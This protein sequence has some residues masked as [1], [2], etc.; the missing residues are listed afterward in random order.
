[1]KSEIVLAPG[2]KIQTRYIIE[3]ELGAGGMGKVFRALD[4]LTNTTVAI[5]ILSENGEEHRE[6]FRRE[7]SFFK[8]AQHPNLLKVYEFFEWNSLL[9]MVIEFI[10]G[11]SMADL[12]K[13]PKILSLPEQLSIANKAARAVEILNTGGILHRDIKPDNIMINLKNGVVKLLDLGIGRDLEGNLNTLTIG[14]LGTLPYLSPEQAEE[15]YSEQSDIFSLGVTLY[16]FFLWDQQSPFYAANDFSVLYKISRYDPPDLYT[17]I[18]D[19]CTKNAQR[20]S[21]VEDNAYQ[22]LSGLLLQAMQKKPEKRWRNSGEMAAK[23]AELQKTFLE[24]E[25]Y[26]STVVHPDVLTLTGEIDAGLLKSLHQIQQE[27]KNK[28]TKKRKK[29]RKKTGHRSQPRNQNTLNSKL[30]LA[31]GLVGIA[32]LILFMNITGEN[33]A[34][35]AGQQQKPE[36]EIAQ[37]KELQLQKA[38]EY[39]DKANV[40]LGRKDYPQAFEYTR[41]SAELGNVYAMVLLGQLYRRGVGVKENDYKAFEWFQKSAEQGHANGMANMGILYLKG[42]G[43]KPNQELAFS[44]IKKAAERG[45]PTGMINLG[46]IYLEKRNFAGAVQ[47]FSRAIALNKSEAMVELGSMYSEGKG[48]TRNFSKSLDLFQRAAALK[49]PQGIYNL[50]I[51][52]EAGHGVQQNY[53]QAWALF[54]QA[55]LLGANYA[56]AKLGE[57]YYQGKGVKKDYNEA[58]NYYNIAASCNSPVGMLYTAMMY[59]QGLGITKNKS[60]A[61]DYYRKAADFQIPIAMH[62]LG[63]FYAEEKNVT[64]A[65]KWFHKSTE[66]DYAPS[67]VHLGRLYEFGAGVKQDRKAA[68]RL[69]TKAAELGNAEARTALRILRQ[70]SDN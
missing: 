38:E 70:L 26:R 59:E 6:R 17:R 22:E 9:C 46:R 53:Q 36:N 4:S 39:W 47:W 28:S 33:K 58:F 42:E 1:M 35:Q 62:K 37:K 67:M 27:T 50:G 19:Q 2:E 14:I 60:R 23:F 15:N 64:E 43:V 61:F 45:S 34:K 11:K 3:Q 48:V 52:Y 49:D 20:L 66:L 18:I 8:I 24:I 32:F 29:I 5:K 40:Y 31:L 55:H 30:F 63:I 69:Y 41:Q 57:F 21:R 10:E 68:I 12:L 7:Y 44:W 65:L 54:K 25:A 13:G 56:T 51:M 16:Q